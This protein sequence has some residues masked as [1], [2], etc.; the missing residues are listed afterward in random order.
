MTIEVLLAKL[1]VLLAWTLTPFLI[2]ID[3]LD[4]GDTP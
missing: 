4:N 3:R 2:L 1:A